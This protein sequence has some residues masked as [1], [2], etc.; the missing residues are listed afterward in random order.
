MR[1]GAPVFHYRRPSTAVEV[2]NFDGLKPRHST[3]RNCSQYRL[4]GSLI[5]A[6]LLVSE[7]LSCERSTAKL[8]PQL[9]GGLACLLDELSHYFTRLQRASR[10]IKPLVCTWATRR[11]RQPLSL[12]HILFLVAAHCAVG[13]AAAYISFCKGTTLLEF[14]TS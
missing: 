7:V 12:S 11:Y 1:S 4:F 2:L 5:M 14:E 9:A 13:L 10:A 8:A 3:R 6:W